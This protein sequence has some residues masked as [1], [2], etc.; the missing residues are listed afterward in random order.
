MRIL[1]VVGGMNRAGIETWLLRIAERLDRRQFQMD[2]L[3]HSAQPYDY[4]PAIQALGH[5][6]IVCPNPSRPWI[7]ARNFRRILRTCGPY[8][9]VH[10]HVHFFTGFVLKLAKKEGVGIRIAHSHSDTRTRNATA[11]FRRKVYLRLCNRWIR[12]HATMQLACSRNAGFSL[13]G[14]HWHEDATRRIL[15]CGIDLAPFTVTCD[16]DAV[17]AELGIPR[18]AFVIGH[19]GRFEPP[20]NH[21]FLLE[22]FA[23]VLRQRSDA[24]LLLVGDGSL[25]T[26]MEEKAS[27]LGLSRAILFAGSRGDVPRLM[28]GAMDCFAFPSLFEGLGLVLVEAQ[29]AGLPCIIS[30]AIPEEAIILPKLVRRLGLHQCARTWAE[31]LLT[32]DPRIPAAHSPENLAAIERSSFSIGNSAKALSALWREA[33]AG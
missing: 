15:H 7:Y 11:S 28:L 3:V 30:D 32:G 17:R 20:K 31:T 8:D 2:F 22:V 24:T 1:H 29:A 27:R 33:Q 5:R 19:V 6:T 13:F 16:R 12:K 21:A 26:A 18:D 10:S 9:A 25:R 14:E 23:Q 4:G